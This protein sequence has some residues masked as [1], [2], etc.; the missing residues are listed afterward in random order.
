MSVRGNICSY[1]NCG[2]SKRTDSSI[3]MFS[4]P[5]KDKERCEKWILNGGKKKIIALKIM[6]IYI[7]FIYR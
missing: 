4:F 6:Y 5:V 7:Y 2:A 3:K 1:H